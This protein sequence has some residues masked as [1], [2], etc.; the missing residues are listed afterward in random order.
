MVF[1]EFCQVAYFELQPLEI[2]FSRRETSLYSYFAYGL[3]IKSELLIPEFTPAQ[4][5]C[6]VSIE[7][8][9][10]SQPNDYLP[11]ETL[12]YYW[13][14][15]VTKENSLLYLKD[16]GI[17][18]VQR[19]QKIVFVPVQNFPEDD[20]IIRLFLIETVMSI[21]LYQRG[22]LVLHA[23]A[24]NLNG[25]AVIFLGNSGEGKST[26]AAAFHAHGYRLLGDDVATIKL[27]QEVAEIIPGLSQIKFTQDTAN[28]L[29]Y[30][31]DSLQMLHQSEEKRVYFPQQN[32]PQTPVP[33]RQIYL[34]VSDLEFAI[35]P[36]T[37]AEAVMQISNHL[38]CTT[39][40]SDSEQ[41]RHFFQCISLVKNH[42][43]C[44]IKRPRNLE[45]FPKLIKLVEEH[46][47][48]DLQPVE[49]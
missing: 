8:D 35:E 30:N 3:N 28:A 43:L 29:G 12:D 48:L 4:G 7:I 13:A 25:G 2:L 20:P 33:I 37:S 23:S 6:D 15:R 40:L 18:L 5:K 45:L 1:A 39:V 27:N 21:L 19:G 9:K 24:V 42:K 22:L 16:K 36:I 46:L 32:L 14:R 34:L 47:A 17:F 41:A 44:C 10:N 11:Q 38:R 49:A 31:F 26:T